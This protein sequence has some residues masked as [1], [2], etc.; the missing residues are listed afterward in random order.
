MYNTYSG[1]FKKQ[2]DKYF[3]KVLLHFFQNV[4]FVVDI[5][6]GQ[7]DFLTQAQKL[8]I[9][10]EGIDDK[11]FWIDHCKKKNF[12]VQKGD[13]Y[14]LPYETNSVSAIF[15]Q[16]VFEHVDA[17][18]SMTE[19]DRITKENGIVAISCPTPE[20]HFWDDPTHV[21]PHTLKSLSTLFEMFGYDV[22]YKNYVF[23]ELLGIH[24]S[25]NGLFKWLNL[26]PASIGSNV[27]VIGKK[28]NK[29]SIQ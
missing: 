23:A 18:Q 17:I 5:G 15:I 29:K 6:C 7:G 9:S 10:A 8:N 12:S 19:I 27:I 11:E 14:N 22:V 3:K 1:F 21:R 2:R 13:I 24:I 26:I 16:S 28:S 25:W 20:K 4:P